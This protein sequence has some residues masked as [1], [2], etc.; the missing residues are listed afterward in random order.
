VT[1]QIPRGAADALSTRYGLDVAEPV[2]ALLQ[3]CE[4]VSLRDGE[5]LC[6]E[7]RPSDGLY[8]LL[9]GAVSVLKKDARLEDRALA[10]AQ[11]PAVLGHMGLVGGGKRTASLASR[12]GVTVARLDATAFDRLMNHDG[13]AG[14]A[15]RRVVLAAMLDQQRRAMTDLVRMLQ[16]GADRYPDDATGWGV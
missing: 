16:P 10:V 4:L 14:D 11:A 8:L 2:H 3:E 7:G 1:Q 13:E 9:D 12:G 15:L 5:L 6:E